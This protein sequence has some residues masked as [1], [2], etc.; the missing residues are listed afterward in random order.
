MLRRNK[1]SEIGLVNGATGVLLEIIAPQGRVE[2]LVVKFDS[3]E[4][5]QTL[6]KV[7]HSVHRPS[8]Y[9]TPGICRL[10]RWAR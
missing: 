6:Y 4:E 1:N 7:R 2:A 10:R 8:T 5:P 3:I 9:F